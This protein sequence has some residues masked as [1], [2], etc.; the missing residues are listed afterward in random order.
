VHDFLHPVL[1]FGMFFYAT[2]HPVPIL[3]LYVNFLNNL[4]SN[5]SK[6]EVF[7]IN[8]ADNLAH[9]LMGILSGCKLQLTLSCLRKRIGGYGM[10][11]D[12]VLL[13]I[14]G[15]KDTSVYIFT[16]WLFRL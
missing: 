8:L 9:I 15:I 11:P 16:F 3:H 14:R 6:S 2:L 10:M 1:I 7:G 5:P 4:K 12:L 13:K